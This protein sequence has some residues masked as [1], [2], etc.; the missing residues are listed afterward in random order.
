MRTG[1]RSDGHTAAIGARAFSVYANGGKL[2]N[3]PRPDRHRRSQGG[4]I[5]SRQKPVNFDS[6]PQV[7]DPETVAE[8]RRILCDVVIRG[9]AQGMRSKIWNISGK[10]GTAHIAE[11]HGYSATRFNSSFMCMAPYENPRIVVVCVIHDPDLNNRA[12]RRQSRRA[13]GRQI[14]GTSADVSGS[15]LVPRSS[16]AVTAGRQRVVGLFG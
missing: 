5:L 12:L 4:N 11:A 13:C 7:I 14:H 6:L 8:M 16:L 9:T 2:I 3:P 10:T 1:L 15:A